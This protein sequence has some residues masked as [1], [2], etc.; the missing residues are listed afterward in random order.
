MHRGGDLLA[1]NSLRQRRVSMGKE[2]VPKPMLKKGAETDLV[3]VE[4]NPWMWQGLGVVDR[5]CPEDRPEDRF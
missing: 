2:S 5:S 3:L 4:G 1:P